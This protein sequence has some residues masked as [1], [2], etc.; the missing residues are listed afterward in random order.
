MKSDIAQT[1]TAGLSPAFEEYAQLMRALH[2]LMRD[3]EDDERG[4]ELRDRLDVPWYRM[5]EAELALARGMSADLFSLEPNSRFPHPEWLAIESSEL[6]TRLGRLWYA[7]DWPAILESLRDNCLGIDAAEA[8]QLRARCW[9]SLGVPETAELFF[10]KASGS[11]RVYALH[12]AQALL[13]SGRIDEALD[14]LQRIGSDS[15]ELTDDDLSRLTQP[16]SYLPPIELRRLLGLANDLAQSSQCAP[17]SRENP[18]PAVFPEAQLGDAWDEALAELRRHPERDPAEASLL[19][20]VYWVH[21]QHPDIAIRFFYEAERQGGREEVQEV[22]LLS[23]LILVGR[24]DEALVRAERIRDGFGGPA[25]LLKGAEVF[26]LASEQVQGA[27]AEAF[28]RASIEMAERALKLPAENGKSQELVDAMAPGVL[29]HLALNYDAL[30]ERERARQAC[31]EA[32]RRDPHSLNAREIQLMLDPSSAT[33]SSKEEVR[34]KLRPPAKP[35]YPLA[36]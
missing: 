6:R 16:W 27:E 8:A 36:A 13:D 29:L 20:G 4:D 22:L 18:A 31:A 33:E 32:L 35:I 23:C 14:G 21:L 11:H 9:E 19:R 15:G 12:R 26:A 28:R 17:Q 25:A 24:F 7:G 3:G 1:A 5:D 2:V 34:K 30:G 10:N